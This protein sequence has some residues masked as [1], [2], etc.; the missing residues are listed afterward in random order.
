MPQISDADAQTLQRLKHVESKIFANAKT[1]KAFLQVYEEADPNFKSGELQQDK[2][3]EDKVNE[4]I[5]KLESELSETRKKLIERDAE[6]ANVR[7]KSRLQR[8]PFNLSDS[9]I[10]EVIQYRAEAY[11]QGEMLS[12]ETAARAWLQIHHVPSGHAGPR[13]PWSTRGNRPKGD[14]REQLKD[15]KSE[16]FKDPRGVTAKAAAEARNELREA[17]GDCLV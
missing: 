14:F 10:D 13:F 9:E 17:F 8:A 6:E 5:G 16:L 1:R 15:P 7:E 4:K 2:A 3:I 11:K 12:L